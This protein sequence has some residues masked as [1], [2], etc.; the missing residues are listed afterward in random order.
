MQQRREPGKL[1]LAGQGTA[2]IQLAPIVPFV[3]TFELLQSLFSKETGRG[4]SVCRAELEEL[5][6]TEPDAY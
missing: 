1:V 2:E 3:R 5:A 6:A 4:R